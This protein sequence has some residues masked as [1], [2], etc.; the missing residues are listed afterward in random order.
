MR[1]R[2][3]LL[4]CVLALIPLGGVSAQT[5]SPRSPGGSG[6]W[7]APFSIYSNW[8]VFPSANASAT[9]V[10]FLNPYSTTPNVTDDYYDRQVL[11]T[12][13]TGGAWSSPV[14]VGSN[15]M[16]RPT[17]WFPVATHPVINA[18]GN[19]IAYLGCTGICNPV[20][21]GDVYDIYVS[22]RGPGG[23]SQPAVVATGA[24][25][26]STQIGLSADGN[27][28]TYSTNYL[29]F[30]F[31]KWNQV[32]IVQRTGETW[33]SPT[34]VSTNDVN[35]WSPALS[36]DGKQVIWISNPPSD[37]I[38][39]NNVLIYASQLSGGGWSSPQILETGLEMST[40]IAQY[41][42]SPDGNS[43][44]FWKVTL[45]GNVCTGTDLY[46]LRRAGAG[47]SSPQ[48][49]T[50]GAL[51][52][53]DSCGLELI[54]GIN[55]DGTRVVYPDPLVHED[56]VDDVSLMMVE[57]KA[58]AWGAPAAVTVHKRSSIYLS[59]LLSDDG[60]RLVA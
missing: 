15:A 17:G 49:V 10:V 54:A 34:V 60:K 57:S 12:E 44:F 50:P 43:I 41:R 59:P 36:R 9:Q 31:Y 24:G 7:S 33:G 2:W 56:V 26:I 42:F 13:Y 6:S 38:L 23:W 40:N 39:P 52:P 8:V 58:G 32:Y 30:P 35:G 45:T 21:Q 14:E 20:T 25:V 3:L 16:Y 18:D 37:S 48:E 51:H 1:H 11:Y 29:N 4:L 53:Y 22:R 55:S 19:T 28:L 47:W 5:G 46:V 27:T